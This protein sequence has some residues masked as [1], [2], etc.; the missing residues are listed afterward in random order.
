VSELEDLCARLDAAADRLRD[1]ELSPD[2]AASLV[3]ECARLA[4]EAAVELERRARAAEE[5]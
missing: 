2:E 3:E 5:S 1:P 4:G